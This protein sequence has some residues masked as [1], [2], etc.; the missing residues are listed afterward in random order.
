MNTKK[1]KKG[2]I[3][4]KKYE[5]ESIFP[6]LYRIGENPF[7]IKTGTRTRIINYKISLS[8]NKKTDSGK[9]P[10]GIYFYNMVKKF[11]I[12]IPGKEKEIIQQNFDGIVE[13][14]NK[15]YRAIGNS[16]WRVSAP[17]GVSEKSKENSQ[18]YNILQNFDFYIGESGE[19]KV[20]NYR[21]EGFIESEVKI[22][23]STAP[24]TSISKPFKLN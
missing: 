2:L 6:T 23:N 13:K 1:I 19:I 17:D 15:E 20:D 8:V 18:G 24:F 9:L 14:K 22:I 5:G 3:I 7:G 10:K 21:E 16:Y 11:E 12:E 4:N